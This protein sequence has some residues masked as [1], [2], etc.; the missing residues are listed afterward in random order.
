MTV[1][2]SK[3]QTGVTTVKVTMICAKLARIS[4][5][6]I[7]VIGEVNRDGE[8]TMDISKD[9]KELANSNFA[10]FCARI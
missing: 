7:G 5:F 2:I 8:N 10:V 4:V 6:V 1:V 9:L 3:K